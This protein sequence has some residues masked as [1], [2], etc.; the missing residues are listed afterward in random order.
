MGQ[1]ARSEI[2]RAIYTYNLSIQDSEYPGELK[3]YIVWVHKTQEGNSYTSTPVLAIFGWLDRGLSRALT[4]TREDIR[5]GSQNLM[6]VLNV[7]GPRRC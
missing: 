7:I 5:G 2:D 4:S 3:D 6:H 1:V